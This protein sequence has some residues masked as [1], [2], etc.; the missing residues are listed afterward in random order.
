MAQPEPHVTA[1]VRGLAH[2]VALLELALGRVTDETL[3]DLTD[4]E[5]VAL[6]GGVTREQEKER[7][8][9]QR[10]EREAREAE[11]RRNMEKAK[12]ASGG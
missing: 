4:D 1:A 3:D 8:R 9:P 10:E 7:R 2:R 11:Y 6:T 5:V 12:K